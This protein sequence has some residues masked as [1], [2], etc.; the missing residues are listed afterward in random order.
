MKNINHFIKGAGCSLAL[1]SSGAFAEWQDVTS[2]FEVSN[3]RPA[4][5]RATRQMNVFVTVKNTSEQTFDSS[6]RFLATTPNFDLT[7]SDFEQGSSE[8][9][10]LAVESL[11]PNEVVTF[12]V[13]YPLSRR[14]L[15]YT[16]LVEYDVPDVVSP[17]DGVTVKVDTTAADSAVGPVKDLWQT[18]NRISPR[19]GVAVR[20]GLNVNTV[21]MIGGVLKRDEEGN[22]VPDLDY[23]VAH[24]DEELQDYV[25]NFAPL[26]ARI[27]AIIAGGTPIHQIVLDQPPWAFQRGYTFIPEGERDG[28]NFRENE[29]ISIYGNSLPPSDEAEYAEFIQALM[30]NLLDTYGKEVIKDWRFR[31]GSE[32]ETPDHWFGTEQDFVEHFGSVAKA[33]RAVFPEAIVGVHT[34]PPGFVFRG[35]RVLNYKGEVIKSFANAIIEYAHDNQIKIDFWGASDYPIITSANT[36]IATDKYRLLFEPLVTH[37]KW[38]ADTKI[39]IQEFSIISKIGGGFL[40]DSDTA[41][42]DTLAIA[43]TDELYKYDVEQIFQWGQRQPDHELWRTRAIRDMVGKVRYSADISGDLA[44]DVEDIGSIVAQDADDR[45]IDILTYNYDPARLE[46]QSTKPIRT[47][48]MTDVPVGS[49]YFYRTRLASR[50]NKK[51]QIFMDQPG[52]DDYLGSVRGFNRYG[53]A[54]TVLTDEGKAAFAAFEF[55]NPSVFGPWESAVTVARPD[56]EAGSMIALESELPLFAFEKTEIEWTQTVPGK[57]LVGWDEWQNSDATVTDGL[58]GTISDQ[59]ARWV[60][61]FRAGSNDGTFGSLA[62]ESGAASTEVGASSAFHFTGFRNRVAGER[63]IDFTVTADAGVDLGVFH[64]DAVT[65]GGQNTDSWTLEVLPDGGVTAGTVATG[66]VEASFGANYLGDLDIDLTALADSRL[67]AG[68]SVTFRLTFN[69][70]QNRNLDIDNVGISSAGTVIGTIID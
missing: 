33:V 29:R 16:A 44:E 48:V 23:D 19:T 22:Q 42:A 47:E 5:D 25:Y 52:A 40:I 34:R 18:A 55:N 41:Q 3:S 17:F 43:M 28:V 70:A 32:I 8:G 59:H 2:N 46:A 54:N 61:N 65:R 20:P 1:L 53:N 13:S 4:F 64:L 50:D 27:D 14:A 56:G 68:E 45:S 21:R 60:R 57:L 66:F 37:P 12:K 69:T 36:R 6:L 7:N 35:G 11:G 49:T 24:Y 15:S 38:Q 30:Q 26:N 10:N 58:T 9:Y 62:K 39:D 67:E 63:S 31:I 51:F